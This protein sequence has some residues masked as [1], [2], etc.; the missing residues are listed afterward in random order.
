MLVVAL[1]LGSA[2]AWGVADFLGGVQNRRLAI[3]AVGVGSQLA[4]LCA[5]TLALLAGGAALPPGAVLGWGAL[6]GVANAAGL[7]A[8]YRALAIGR[9]SIVAPIV[10][11]SALLPVCVGLISGERPSGLQAAGIVVGIAGVVLASRELD[12]DGGARSAARWSFVLAVLAAAGVGA[13]LI[14]LEKGVAASGGSILWPIGAA[15]AVAVVVIVAGALAVRAPF[16]PPAP[17]W[18]G[19]AALGLIDLAANVL[20][21]LATR[22]TLLSVAA[23]LASLHPVTTILLARVL[24]GERLRRVQQGGVA[25]ALLGVCLIAG[26]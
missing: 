7:V 12:R 17:R 10:G 4:A 5:C 21:T 18:T 20:Y 14:F 16:A 24:L 13:N 19:L 25:L 11:M 3:A 2:I 8:F 26:G 6:A 22:E 23:V 15:R 1:G 9:M